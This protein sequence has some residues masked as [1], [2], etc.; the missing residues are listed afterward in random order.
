MHLTSLL[1]NKLLL[2]KDYGTQELAMDCWPY[3]QFEENIKIV[4]ELVEEEETQR[5]KQE[6]AQQAQTPSFN[7]GSIMNKMGS[8]GNKF[9]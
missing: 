1:R 8:M 9:K 3:W 5:K 7:P 2:Q 6:S 4:N